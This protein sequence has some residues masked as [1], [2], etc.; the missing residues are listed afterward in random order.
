MT[1]YNPGK[2]W[3]LLAEDNPHEAGLTLRALAATHAPPEVVVVRDGSEA[4]DCLYRRGRFQAR[5]ERNPALVVLDLQMPKVGGL[6]VLRQV[7]SDP[8]LRVIPIVM[9]TASRCPTDRIRCY[10]LGANAFVVK[11]MVSR[12]YVAAVEDLR[13][14]WVLVNEPPPEEPGNAEEEPAQLAAAA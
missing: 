5:I 9:L 10:Q 2:K 6:E 1:N 12:Q 14:F 4:L 13:A 7:K 8:Q 11:P 3:I